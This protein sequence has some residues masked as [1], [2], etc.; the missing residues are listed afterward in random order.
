MNETLRA[1]LVIARR[2][3]SA[4]IF[5]KTFIFFLLG[6]LFPLF[7]AVAAGGLTDKIGNEGPKP[8]LGI[9]LSPA[10]TAKIANARSRLIIDLGNQALPPLQSFPAGS[11]PKQLLTGRDSKVTTVL[12]GT[13]AAPVLTGKQG[14]IDAMRHNVSLLVGMAS[15]EALPPLVTLKTQALAQAG[16]GRRDNQLITAHAAQVTLFLLTMLLAGMVLSNMVEEKTNKVIE[17]LAAA[18]PID[19]IF[20]GKLIAM[21]GMSLTGIAIW[22]SCAITGYLLL[23]GTNWP[24]PPPAVGWPVF[25]LL[26][27]AYFMTAYVLLGSL[28]LGIGAQAGTVREVQTLSMPVTMGQVLIFFLASSSVEHMGSF[29]ETAAAI[30]PL[31]SPFAMIARAAQSDALWPHLLAIGWQLLCVMLI[32][33]MGVRL[34]RRNVMKSG[35]AGRKRRGLFGR[36]RSSPSPS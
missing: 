26:G 20:L 11:D 9:A 3:Y 27:I 22:A 24:L 23:I 19:S 18:V 6:P 16:E 12:S 10:E 2:D 36:S 8:V 15:A 21:L 17:V 1:A 33:R 5:S 29:R 25:I 32:V 28:F 31:S 7:I 35:S 13:L 4:V 34:F 30:F 14:N